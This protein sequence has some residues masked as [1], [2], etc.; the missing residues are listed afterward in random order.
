MTT[1]VTIVLLC[2]VAIGILVT[3]GIRE[4]RRE[5]ERL[6]TRLQKATKVSNSV[7]K[8][9]QELKQ[10]RKEYNGDM[11]V[12]TERIINYNNKYGT[13]IPLP[14]KPSGKK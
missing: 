5:R 13:S 1:Q 11:D 10:I 6:E 8:M 7:V 4:R 14:R 12:L 3:I 9:K 2:I